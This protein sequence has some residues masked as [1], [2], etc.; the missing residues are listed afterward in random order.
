MRPGSGPHDRVSIHE[1]ELLCVVPAPAQIIPVEVVRCVSGP[2]GVETAFVL[3]QVDQHVLPVGLVVVHA[4]IAGTPAVVAIEEPVLERGPASLTDH[5]AVVDVLLFVEHHL[6]VLEIGG[7]RRNG[8]HRA[9]QQE[10]KGEEGVGYARSEAAP[11]QP[12]HPG[13]EHVTVL[14][15]QPGDLGKGPGALGHI[16]TVVEAQELDGPERI[17]TGLRQGF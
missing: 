11:G 2:L 7:G 9:A 17:L 5:A 6:P 14:P 8:R 1:F 3:V 10:G 16:Q 12:A 13:M 4:V 15:A